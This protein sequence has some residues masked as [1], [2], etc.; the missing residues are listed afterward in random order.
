MARKS[1]RSGG[2]T[3]AALSAVRIAEPEVRIHL[4]PAASQQRT[5]PH[6]RAG[7]GKTRLARGPLKGTAS[8]APPLSLALRSGVGPS[9]IP[10]VRGLSL[11]KRPRQLGLGISAF[12]VV[13]CLRR[14]HFCFV[15]GVCRSLDAVGRGP[16]RCHCRVCDLVPFSDCLRF[17]HG[18]LQPVC[19]CCQISATGLRLEMLRS[20][21]RR[22]S[23]SCYRVS[24]VI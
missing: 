13:F 19:K 23:K 15:S 8:P 2:I 4:P 11:V 18:P 17:R 9:P 12:L 7:Q 24:L 14:G 1:G 20:R 16:G 22:S 3:R 5:P 6:Q 10:Q 21:P